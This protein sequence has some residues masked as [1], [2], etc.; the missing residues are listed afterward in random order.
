MALASEILSR[1]QRLIQDETNVRWPLAELCEWLNDGQREII[2]HKPSALSR[3][4]VINLRAG[5]WQAI[6]DTALALLKIVRNINSVGGPPNNLRVGGAAIRAVAREVLDATRPDW[7]ASTATPAPKHY[8]YDED[9]PRSF[10]VWPP[11]DGTGKVEAILSMNPATVT[12]TG[13]PDTL[14]SYN[15]VLSLADIYMSALVDFVCYRAY[16]KDASFAGS[17]Q[18]AAMHYQQFANAIGIKARMELLDSPNTPNGAK[19][20]VTGAG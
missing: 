5:T 18:R 19:A 2:L 9:D 11:N 14:G 13:A 1:A 6:P 4:D 8:I 7:H 12:A 16:S 10:Y 3:T 17:A 15:A 20:A